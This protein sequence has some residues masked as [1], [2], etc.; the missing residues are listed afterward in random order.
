MTRRRRFWLAGLSGAVALAIGS[1]AFN[2]A[3]HLETVAH[4]E[5]SEAEHVDQQLAQGFH[6]LFV[7]R[8]VLVIQGLPSPDSPEGEQALVQITRALRS[9]PGVSGTLS[10]LDRAD[11]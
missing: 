7:H 1:Q 6:S 2:V 4:V 5:G 11:P 10:H 3:E 9:E 8:V